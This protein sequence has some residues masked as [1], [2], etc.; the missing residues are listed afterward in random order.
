M[1][2]STIRHLAVVVLAILTG[3]AVW[4]VAR[5]IGVELDLKDGAPSDQVGAI[6]V[7]VTTFLVSLAA[8]AVHAALVSRHL[9]WHWP[10]VG[11]TVLSIS[12]IA[13]VWLADGDAA[14]ALIAMHFAVGFVLITGFGRFVDGQ[15]AEPEYSDQLTR[16]HA[17]LPDRRPR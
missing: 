11:S 15:P 9:A 17:G 1:T 14:V 5:L 3:L 12:I 4:G 16:Q 6:D 7:L 13:P 2:D 8:W 10:L